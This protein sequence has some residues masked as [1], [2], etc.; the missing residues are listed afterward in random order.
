MKIV[1]DT[2]VLISGILFRGHPRRILDWAAQGKLMNCAS[3]A[4]LREAENVLSRP[5]FGLRPSEVANILALFRDTFEMVHPEESV[6]AIRDDPADNRVHEAA[7]AAAADF[8][9]SGDRHLLQLKEWQGIQII[10]PGDFDSVLE[11]QE[12]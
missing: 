4:L 6:T 10:S 11:G 3:P 1:C 8:I 5:K 7:G 2:N 12:R 9:V